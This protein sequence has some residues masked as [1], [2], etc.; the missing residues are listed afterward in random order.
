MPEQEKMSSFEMPRYRINVLNEDRVLEYAYLE[1]FSELDLNQF[2]PSRFECN[3]PDFWKGAD[4]DCEAF[5]KFVY[6]G[7]ILGLIRFA[8]YPYPPNGG[9]ADVGGVWPLHWVYWLFL[10]STP[11]KCLYFQSMLSRAVMILVEALPW[12]DAQ[13]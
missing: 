6:R 1:Q 5:I 10:R 3:W 9:L 12:R 11:G 7:Q 13:G 8:I 2:T 4:F